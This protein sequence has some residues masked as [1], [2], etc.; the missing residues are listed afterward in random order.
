MNWINIKEKFPDFEEE[1]ALAYHTVY[2]IG[3]AWFWRF[4]EDISE[5]LEE[6]FKDKYIGSCHF[7]KN[8]Y[9]GNCQIDDESDIDIFLR[10]PH[11]NNEGTVLYWMP[12]PD[13]PASV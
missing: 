3:V 8:K 5:N 11:F 4:E 12:L 13:K 7:I 2:G 9:D 6:D 10:S 1:F